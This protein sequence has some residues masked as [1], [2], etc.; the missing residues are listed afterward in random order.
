MLIFCSEQ[1][2]S[3]KLLFSM[4]H[5]NKKSTL[6]TSSPYSALYSEILRSLQARLVIFRIRYAVVPFCS[7]QSKPQAR[8]LSY[9]WHI[10]SNNATPKETKTRQQNKQG[11]SPLAAKYPPRCVPRI[12]LETVLLLN[13]FFVCTLT[14]FVYIL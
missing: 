9:I 11:L 14:S 3:I 6:Q 12:L 10:E 5:E 13:D 4:Q 2:Q 7:M 8:N 1:S